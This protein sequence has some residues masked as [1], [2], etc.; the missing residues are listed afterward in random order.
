MKELVLR[1]IATALAVAAAVWL[2]PGIAIEDGPAVSKIVTLLIV[3]VLMGL[4]N[5]VIKPL[6]T[7]ISGCFIVITF[8][9]FLL[10]IN[11]AML[12]I[13]SGLAGVLGL[14]FTV[15]GWE[16]ALFGSIVI[17]L[18]SWLLSGVF[19]VRKEN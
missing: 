6:A 4:V 15:A 2:I 7:F 12:M 8:G 11:A 5:A 13:V 17:S 10:V 19:G 14:G 16:A 3:A 18:V 9:L 1:W